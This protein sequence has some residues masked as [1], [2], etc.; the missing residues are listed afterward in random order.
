MPF[1]AMLVAIGFAWYF[2][3]TGFGMS[4]Q[5]IILATFATICC[6]PLSAEQN[7][8][9][10]KCII[11]YEPKN[12]TEKEL[13][14]LECSWSEGAIDRDQKKLAR[15]FADD[16]IGLVQ[17]QTLNKSELIN[18][19]VKSKTQKFA[20]IEHSDIHI[21]VFGD[22]AVVT[23]WTKIRAREADGNES[24]KTHSSVDVFRRRN[25]KWQC[26]VS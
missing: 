9:P 15:V 14:A 3:A 20:P 21:R 6:G 26:V 23:R 7:K 17:N 24:E 19:Y 5:A 12:P 22:I 4:K 11:H 1:V 18:Y 10:P 16:M 8:G 2:C 13:L 25:G